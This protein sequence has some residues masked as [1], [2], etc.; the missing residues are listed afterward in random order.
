VA[1][2]TGVSVLHA[3]VESIACSA[4]RNALTSSASISTLELIDLG[5]SD[6]T[7]GLD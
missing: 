6:Q 4:V 7:P 5:S 2:L 1:P 3:A